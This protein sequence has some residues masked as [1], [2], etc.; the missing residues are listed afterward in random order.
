MRFYI[1]VVHKDP[2][3]DFGISFPDFPGCISAGA[4][5]QEASEMGREALEGHIGVMSDIGEAIPE[6]S[7]MDAVIA[8]PV[9]REGTAVLIPIT[10]ANSRSVRINITMPADALGEID[11]YA[12]RHGFTRSGFL[13]AAAKKAMQEA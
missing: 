10:L 8:D 13:A 5:L 4:T 12:E 6:P 1:G 9:F 7:S 2:E 3:S 11:A